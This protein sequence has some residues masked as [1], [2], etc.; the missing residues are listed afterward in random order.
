MELKIDHDKLKGRR[1]F[2][3][4]PM[5]GGQCHADFAFAIAQLSA[6]CAQLGIGLRFHFHCNES[7]VMRARN[8]TV[9]EFL[10]SGDTHL[11]FI[12]ADI[13][14]DA[15]DVL[16]LLAMQDEDAAADEYDVVTAPYP[17]KRFD[18]ERIARA[19]KAGVADE[20]PHMLE[21]HAGRMV[22]SPVP[23]APFS[24]RHPVEATMAG[25]GF[26]M[27]R[28][29]TFDAYRAAYPA[30]AY[31]NDPMM[32]AQGE[33]AELFAY[34]DTGIDAK[35]ANLAEELK[36]FLAA[37]PEAGRDEIAA[38]LA[39]ST[40]ASGSYSRQY[41]SEDYLFCHRLRAAGMRLWACP[42]MQL[43][44]SGG[45]TFSTSLSHLVSR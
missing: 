27:V 8:A 36:L 22:F 5:Y 42:W 45:Y 18:W 4:T 24:L 1:L 26:M 9:G 23:G 19:A 11:M 34:F 28:R 38:F 41:V 16:Y 15:K 2:V 44:H 31:V 33:P 30:F 12:D 29:A 13:G 10:R 43:T 6:L 3:G 39:D 25:A 21:K 35:A 40:Q 7:L 32:V 37:R 20:H 17:L 14:F